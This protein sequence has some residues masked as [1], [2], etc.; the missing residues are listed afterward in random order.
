MLPD[1]A[2]VPAYQPRTRFHPEF[3]ILMGLA[4]VLGALVA[5][6]TTP[7]TSGPVAIPGAA[8]MAVASWSVFAPATWLWFRLSP[9]VF[10]IA[11]RGFRRDLA[12]TPLDPR[13]VLG[14]ELGAR[15]VFALVPVVLHLLVAI[16]GLAVVLTTGEQRYGMQLLMVRWGINTVLIAVPLALLMLAALSFCARW[17]MARDQPPF[18]GSP[19]LS[20][21]IGGLLAFA[22]WVALVQLYVTLSYSLLWPLAQWLVGIKA[23][24]AFHWVVFDLLTHA[25]AGLV[26][27]WAAWRCLRANVRWVVDRYFDDVS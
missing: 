26:V 9:T 15:H 25:L 20:L 3:D 27:A 8:V 5:D 6:Q 23:L 2:P 18:L 17:G 16:Y 19:L 11:S 24:S 4:L 14:G 1:D 7:S 22:L 12:P 10:R 21:V 13:E